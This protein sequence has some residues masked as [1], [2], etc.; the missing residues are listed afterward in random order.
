MRY[1][2]DGGISYD[3]IL[4]VPEA[5]TLKQSLKVS[6]EQIEQK[7]ALLHVGSDPSLGRLQI[8]LLTDGIYTKD[9]KDYA[10]KFGV[11]LI[12]IPA[13][14]DLWYLPQLT[15]DEIWDYVIYHIEEAF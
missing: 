1:L 10:N 6:L 7:Q 2:S 9:Y 8:G 11:T 13:S 3:R 5:L 12:S 15:V 14:I 4:V